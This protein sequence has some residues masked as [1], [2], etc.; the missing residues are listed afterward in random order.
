MRPP[1]T[2]GTGLNQIDH[3]DWPEDLPGPNHWRIDSNIFC[4]VPDDIKEEVKRV[5][6]SSI[7]FYQK[8]KR[9]PAPM[10][11]GDIADPD[12]THALEFALDRQD[13]LEKAIKQPYDHVAEKVMVWLQER[14][15]S[16][17][18]S[19]KA[20]VFREGG[21]VYDEANRK[22]WEVKLG[23][24]TNEHV[25][26][27]RFIFRT[28]MARVNWVHTREEPHKEK[29]QSTFEEAI[30]QY[31]EDSDI[32]FQAAPSGSFWKMDDSLMENSTL[33]MSQAALALYHHG[34]VLSASW[35]NLPNI[36]NDPNLFNMIIRAIYLTI[37]SIDLIWVEREQNLAKDKEERLLTRLREC[38]DIVVGLRFKL[39][40]SQLSSTYDGHTVKID[41]SGFISVMVKGEYLVSTTWF[42]GAASGR[43]VRLAQVTANIPR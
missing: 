28:V 17:V 21:E 14:K 32:E 34:R 9:Q 27:L 10:I 5:V 30:V 11:H 37:R 12:A 39:I 33:K 15:K 40:E 42:F 13:E 26:Q 19:M 41:N 38:K 20:L 4:D 1:L 25:D 16:F 43:F 22:P 7:R 24:M 6:E 8:V 23:K 36:E 29:I 35:A 31:E 18:K 3:V 2:I